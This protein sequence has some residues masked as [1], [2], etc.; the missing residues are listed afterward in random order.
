MPKILFDSANLRPNRLCAICNL[1][2]TAL[3]TGLVVTAR[4]QV[5]HYRHL[6][7]VHASCYALLEEESFEEETNQ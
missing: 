5:S 3:T 6:R 2:L 4:G 7:I 1:P